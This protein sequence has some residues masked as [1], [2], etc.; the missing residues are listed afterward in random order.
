MFRSALEWLLED[1][2]FTARML[3]PKLTA[4]DVA[5]AKGSGPHWIS[6]VDPEYMRVIKDLGNIATHTNAGELEKQE[7]LDSQLYR[8]VELAFW[9]LLDIIYERPAKRARRLAELRAV[10]G[11]A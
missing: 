3:G 9:E 1:Q 4:L 10:T 8:E 5:I 11:R 6:E 2:G 7:T